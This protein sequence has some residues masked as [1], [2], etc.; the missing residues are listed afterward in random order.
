M[1]HGR[2][3]S[4]CESMAMTGEISGRRFQDGFEKGKRVG[5]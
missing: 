5:K 4:R 3:K 1:R 2:D